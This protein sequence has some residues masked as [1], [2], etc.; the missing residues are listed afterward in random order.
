MVRDRVVERVARRAARDV[1]TVSRGHTGAWRSLAAPLTGTGD[2][3]RV[4]VDRHDER[5]GLT[6]HLA[7]TWP[8][9]LPGATAAARDAVHD[10][11]TRFAGLD[12]ERTDV[13]VDIAPSAPSRADDP[14]ST[15]PGHSAAASSAPAARPPVL[16][17]RAVVPS[18]LLALGLVGLGVVGVR[19]ALVS[20][21][22]LSG[23]P[24]AVSVA[25][26]VSGATPSAV[27]LVAGVLVALLGL[28][29]VMAAV[30][31]RPKPFLEVTAGSDVW[32]RPRDVARLVR[33]AA[34]RVGGVG[35]V[36]TS[37]SR[38]KV[39]VT[40]TD[41]TG[42]AELEAPVREAVEAAMAGLA[43]PPRV[44]VRM[45][46]PTVQPAPATPSKAAASP[47]TFEPTTSEPTTSEPT[48]SEPT[49]SEPATSEPTT[50]ATAPSS[51]PVS[52][53]PTKDVS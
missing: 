31:P 14:A 7:V 24:W 51:K 22:V 34:A 40:V 23:T 11:V 12:V 43:R 37:V 4:D 36:R 35:G 30:R 8:E 47:T 46:A 44:T 41:R 15:A 19:D 18:A 29:F 17:P 21:G 33:G 42:S 16:A 45:K 25:D 50:S 26:A 28:W 53:S 1:D 5:V 2:G 38:R 3:T 49:T 6:V 39:Q 13:L 20:S 27:V 48:T 52:S 32:I 9:S 10:A